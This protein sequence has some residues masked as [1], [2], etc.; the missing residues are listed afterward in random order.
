M[1]LLKRIARYQAHALMFGALALFSR[2]EWIL[3]HQQTKLQDVEFNNTLLILLL[4]IKALFS[5]IIVAVGAA[6][7]WLFLLKKPAESSP[8]MKKHYNAVLLAIMC[9]VVILTH[10]QAAIVV[11]ASASNPSGIA[12]LRFISSLHFLEL[13]TLFVLL[14][15]WITLR[16]GKVV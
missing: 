4:L 16:P 6:S 10:A 11:L 12:S 3:L 14:S 13:I 5:F 9:T 15:S 1:T 8:A 2:L 7:I